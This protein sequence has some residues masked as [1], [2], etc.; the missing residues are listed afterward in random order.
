MKGYNDDLVMS[1]GIC[2]WIRDTTL[3]LRVKG[4]HTTKKVNGIF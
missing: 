4:N 2:L 1:L 3:R